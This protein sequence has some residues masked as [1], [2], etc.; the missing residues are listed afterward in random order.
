MNEI[1]MLVIMYL[2]LVIMTGIA[3][4]MIYGRLAKLEKN[5]FDWDDVNDIAFLTKKLKEFKEIK[6]KGEL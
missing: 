6:Q 4:N 3:L 1:H 2:I 5:S